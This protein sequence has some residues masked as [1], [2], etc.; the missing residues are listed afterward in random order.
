M[1]VNVL[2]FF[3]FLMFLLLTGARLEIWFFGSL[4]LIWDFASRISLAVQLNLDNLKLATDATPIT[5]QKLMMS[6]FLLD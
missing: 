1:E 3:I 5:C 2:L 4:I 6:L